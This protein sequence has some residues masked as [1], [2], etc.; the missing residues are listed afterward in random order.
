MFDGH[1]LSGVVSVN[2]RSGSVQFVP[3]ESAIVF[4]DGSPDEDLTEKSA[5]EFSNSN[6]E[7]CGV[8]LVVKS[9]G[10][11]LHSIPSD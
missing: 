11:E 7:E 4:K 5:Q 3:Y 2:V 6:H 10:G 8:E 9:R 1:N